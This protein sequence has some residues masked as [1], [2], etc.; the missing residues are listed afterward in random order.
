MIKCCN[1]HENDRFN[2]ATCKIC[3][4]SLPTFNTDDVQETVQNNV[5]ET[6]EKALITITQKNELLLKYLSDIKIETKDQ[7]V[8][9][10]D[11][12]TN[13]RYAVKEAKEKLAELTKPFKDSIDDVKRQFNPFIDQVDQGILSITRAM[14]VWDFEQERLAK[15]A[16]KAATITEVN[17]NTGELV[18]TATQVE[19]PTKTVQSNVGSDTRRE[20]F[21]IQ[22]TDPDLVPRMYCTPDPVKIRAGFKLTDSIPGVV[23]IPKHIYTTRI[24]GG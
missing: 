1:G 15:E 3:G 17:P 5:Q 21:D 23:K 9:C 7:R 4:A 14:S 10:S 6:P 20:G 16:L 8:S 11:M 24:K 22:V 13:A 18:D 19:M 12:L 2:G